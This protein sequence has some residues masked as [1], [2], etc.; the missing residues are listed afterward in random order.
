MI[1]FKMTTK[2]GTD[3]NDQEKMDNDYMCQSFLIR[4]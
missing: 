1:S 3:Y 4:F 2:M